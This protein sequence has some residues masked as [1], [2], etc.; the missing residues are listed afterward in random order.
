MLVTSGG[1]AA[2]GGWGERK[3]TDWSVSLCDNVSA[4]ACQAFHQAQSRRPRLVPQA[5]ME[6]ARCLL[7]VN[8]YTRGGAPACSTRDTFRMIADTRRTISF[9]WF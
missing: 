8:S 5:S 4:N 1:L 7:Y 3:R 9:A 2:Q 6:P